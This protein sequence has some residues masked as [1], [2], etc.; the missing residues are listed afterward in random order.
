MIMPKGEL[1]TSLMRFSLLLLVVLPSLLVASNWVAIAWTQTV[2]WTYHVGTPTGGTTEVTSA[3]RLAGWPLS[4]N[5]AF[6]SESFGWRNVHWFPLL[7]NC[8][9]ATA[10]SVT[11]F[12]LLR[13]V[14]NSSSR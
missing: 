10:T 13:Y 2:D 5:V 6:P 12:L 1:R 3:V 14:A 11:V 7:A 4:Y 9:I 8:L